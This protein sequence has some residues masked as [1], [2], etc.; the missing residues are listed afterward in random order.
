[1]QH[2]LLHKVEKISHT[3]CACY[4]PHADLAC[5]TAKLTPHSLVAKWSELGRQLQV[6][7]YSHTCT[8]EQ[9]CM[10]KPYV[11]LCLSLP[12]PPPSPFSLSRAV[13]NILLA[14]GRYKYRAQ[15]FW[16][17][18]QIINHAHEITSRMCFR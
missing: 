11:S 10:L 15:N 1:M 14:G 13:P 12:L 6:Y 17:R 4:I 5:T 2:H 9:C 3:G 18:P 8:I 16:S 7:L